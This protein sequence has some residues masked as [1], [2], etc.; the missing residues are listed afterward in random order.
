MNKYSK[1]IFW[2]LFQADYKQK[3]IYSV[4]VLCFQCMFIGMFVHN[5]LRH[6]NFLEAWWKFVGHMNNVRVSP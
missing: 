6:A 4:L 3:C 2:E 1:Y 5:F